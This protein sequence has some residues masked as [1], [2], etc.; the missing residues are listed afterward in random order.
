MPAGRRT[1]IPSSNWTEPP[2]LKSQSLLYLLLSMS[3]SSSLACGLPPQSIHK[4]PCDHP[5]DRRANPGLAPVTRALRHQ[6]NLGPDSFTLG[7]SGYS[8]RLARDKVSVKQAIW[9]SI[10]SGI[11][12][13]PFFTGGRC[14]HR[15]CVSAR[16]SRLRAGLEAGLEAG[17][18]WGIRLTRWGIRL[19]RQCA[20]KGRKFVD[21]G[22]AGF[23]RGARGGQ[24]GA[25]ARGPAS[26][27][28]VARIQSGTLVPPGL[29]K[30][31]RSTS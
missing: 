7:R 16:C 29:T 24:R 25:N 17:G 23:P 20:M 28:N 26:R 18:W 10:F 5:C 8:E 6:A 30:R 3:N 13:R 1:G 11:Y 15:V 2:R 4:H 27:I 22:N 31:S 19:T 9:R 14:R 21:A 12:G